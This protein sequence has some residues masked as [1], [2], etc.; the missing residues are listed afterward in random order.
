MKTENEVRKIVRE[1]LL[2]FFDRFK[3]SEPEESKLPNL[4]I[5][6]TMKIKSPEE[7]ASYNLS[8]SSSGQAISDLPNLKGMIFKYDGFSITRIK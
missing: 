5:G 6:E 3:S 2:S 4:E 1:S 8:L 7:L